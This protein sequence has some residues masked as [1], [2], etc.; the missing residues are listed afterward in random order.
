DTQERM[1][2]VEKQ[3]ILPKN[4]AN[5]PSIANPYATNTLIF[6]GPGRQAIVA[7]L[8]RIHLDNVTYDGLPL[9]EVL[10]QLSE[11]SKLRDPDRKGIN[12]LINNNPDLSG[13]PV[14]A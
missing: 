5:L 12:F 2:H 14:E 11:Q 10:K 9:N 1:E 13:Q 8:D 6:T 3:W 7:K 4:S